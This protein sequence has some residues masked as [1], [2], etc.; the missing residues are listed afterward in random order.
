MAI[1]SVGFLGTH[2]LNGAIYTLQYDVLRDFEP[3][4][5]LASNP[6]LITRLS[7][8]PEIPTMDD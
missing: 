2:V 4:A 6:Q 7:S 5:L 8:A 1:L 3:V